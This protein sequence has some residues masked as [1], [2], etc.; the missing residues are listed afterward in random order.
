VQVELDLVQVAVAALGRLDPSDDPLQTSVWVIEDDL[1]RLHAL[2][3]APGDHAAAPDKLDQLRAQ[4]GMQMRYET[5]GQA[6]AFARCQAQARVRSDD[7]LDAT[8]D[9]HAIA[10]GVRRTVVSPVAIGVSPSGVLLYVHTPSK[11]HHGDELNGP[12]LTAA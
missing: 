3:G 10:T 5:R 7:Q 6:A 4:R 11:P 9:D 1:D 8:A 12:E 2:G